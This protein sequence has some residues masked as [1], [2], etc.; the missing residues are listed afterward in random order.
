MMAK[1]ESPELVTMERGIHSKRRR[2][3]DVPYRFARY[4]H[5]STEDASGNSLADMPI[6]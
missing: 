6:L 1:Y 5:L 3:G 4:H 2:R